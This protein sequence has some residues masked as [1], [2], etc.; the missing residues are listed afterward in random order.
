MQTV[1]VLLLLLLLNVCLQTSK[2][3]REGLTVTRVEQYDEAEEKHLRRELALLR[4][5]RHPSIVRYLGLHVDEQR[6]HVPR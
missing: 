6:A 1:L 4:S 2:I 3:T 5:L